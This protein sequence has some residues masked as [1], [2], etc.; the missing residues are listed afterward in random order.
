MNIEKMKRC[1]AANNGEI[2]YDCIYQNA[3][4]VNVYTESVM[5]ADV[6]TL[7]GCICAINPSNCE[8]VHYIDCKDLFLAPGFWDAHMHIET[9]HLNPASW[10]EITLPHGTTGIFFD[11]MMSGSVYGEACFDMLEQLFEQVPTRVFYQIPSRVPISEEIETTGGVID[12]DSIQRLMNRK[13]VSSLGEVNG[14]SVIR[15]EES[16]FW[17]M[18]RAK[19]AGKRINGHC[20][21]S[22]WDEL[23]AVAVAGITDDHESVTY[24]EL[25]QKLSLGFNVMVREGSIEP[26]VEALIRGVVENNLPIDHLLFCTDDK[27]PVDLM[28]NGHVDYAVNKA[29]D[30]GLDPVKAIKMATLNTAEYYGVSNLYGSITP[31]RM[32]DMILFRDIEHIVPEQVYIGDKLVAKDGKI[33]D[34]IDYGRMPKDDSLHL[35]K[36]LTQ[37]DLYICS[38]N[39]QECCRIMQV[40]KNDLCTR[41]LEQMVK[42]CEGVLQ[43][44]VEQD[45]LPIAVI[46]RYG[47]EGGIGKGFIKG[48]QLK[49]GAIAS[50]LASE[51]N[52]IVVCGT[53]YKDMAVAVN[54]L[55]RMGGGMII[56]EKEKVLAKNPMPIGGIMYDCSAE[57]AI[58]RLQKIEETLGELDCKN[59]DAF[60]YMCVATAPS[61]PVLGLTD[62]GLIDVQQQNIVS[63]FCEK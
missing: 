29:I 19:E 1:V 48:L 33:I 59:R 7:D 18:Q 16:T 44:D 52:N 34:A 39:P 2:P 23:N 50:S 24:Q 17:K 62:K 12:A 31:G 60:T 55:V 32:A 36:Q 4:V 21:K 63:L 13:K 56:V 57:E 46:E 25:V 30:C 49:R 45:I 9:S 6:A 22:T 41:E 35:R 38:S 53:E 58:T 27:Y 20:P 11:P 42:S 51:G 28:K 26:N 15:G 37:E 8:A 47:K 43:A 3:K 61:I 10:A 40:C 14:I 54:E 5:K